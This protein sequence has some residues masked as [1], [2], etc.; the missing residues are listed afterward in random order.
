MGNVLE[1]IKGTSTRIVV[2]DRFAYKIRRVGST[3]LGEAGF[4]GIS[5]I[6]RAAIMAAVAAKAAADGE[7]GSATDAA[8]AQAEAMRTAI[9]GIT[10]KQLHALHR[11]QE[12]TVIA[13]VV[14]IGGPVQY[15]TSTD[16]DTPQVVRNEDGDPVVGEWE[17][18]QL[19]LSAKRADPAQGTL[20]VTNLPGGTRTIGVLA[21]EIQQLSADDGEA[22]DLLAS[23][24]SGAG[25]ARTA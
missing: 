12:Q 17:T 7:Q 20:G 11:Q 19:M 8:D 24:C 14:A 18:V 15:L 16:A 5:M 2:V 22:A 4:A 9:G 10:P 25:R 23:F 13:G 3:E 21:R 1:A 6:P